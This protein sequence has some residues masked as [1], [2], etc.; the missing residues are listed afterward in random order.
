MFESGLTQAYDE[1]G[2]NKYREVYSIPFY[3][4]A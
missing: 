4:H 1:E 3:Y 2:K